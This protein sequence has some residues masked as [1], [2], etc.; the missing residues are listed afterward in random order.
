[1]VKGNKL[2]PLPIIGPIVVSY[3]RKG[4]F[5]PENRSKKGA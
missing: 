4:T 5:N 1:M 3:F 2:T